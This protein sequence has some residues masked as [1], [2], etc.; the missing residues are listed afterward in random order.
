VFYVPKCAISILRIIAFKKVLYAPLGAELNNIEIL[1]R[2][3][4][5]RR[6]NQF[7]LSA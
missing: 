2:D 7:S 1:W 5:N 3:D 6:R 4:P